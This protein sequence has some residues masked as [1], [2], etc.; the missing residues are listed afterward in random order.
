MY[1]PTAAQCEAICEAIPAIPRFALLS[2]GSTL[3][4]IPTIT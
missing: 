3:L 2:T 1:P 4:T